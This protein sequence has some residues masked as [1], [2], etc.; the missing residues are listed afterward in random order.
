[1]D[2]LLSFSEISVFLYAAERREGALP[3]PPN[4]E[5]GHCQRRRTK[6]RGA[7]T[8]YIGLKREEEER[9]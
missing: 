2:T 7:L 8:Q 9:V 4:G 5:R 1:M 3:A 6:L